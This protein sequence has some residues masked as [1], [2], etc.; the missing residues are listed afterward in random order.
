MTTQP[1]R[2]RVKAAALALAGVAVL[3][4]TA[5]AAASAAT[6]GQQSTGVPV[7]VTCAQKTQV[8]PATFVLACGDGNASLDSLHW[9]AWGASS[10]LASGT[11]G[12]DDCTPDCVTGH[13]HTFPALI[14]LWGAKALPGHASVRYFSEMTIIYTGNRGY[15]AGGKKY[16]V[17]QTETD[18]LSNFGGA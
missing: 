6:V 16:T 14:V 9:S 7:V 11:S 13:V 15:T 8:R 2:R 18:P 1:G 12:F 4:T 10:A 3:A 17:P 5:C